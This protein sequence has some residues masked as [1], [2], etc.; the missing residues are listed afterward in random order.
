MYFKF[1][2]KGNDLNFSFKKYFNEELYDGTR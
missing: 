1:N 2:L